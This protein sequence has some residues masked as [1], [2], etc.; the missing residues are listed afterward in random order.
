MNQ[1]TGA[2]KR[3]RTD[4]IVLGAFPEPW[5]KSL[6]DRV[7]SLS[8]VP[9]KDPAEIQDG[10][11][12]V[13]IRRHLSVPAI[14]GGDLVG[15]LALANSRRDYSERDLVRMKRL[16]SVYAHAIKRLA[17]DGENQATPRAA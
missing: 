4:R 9:T 10:F 2:G 5:S 6:T 14:V 1:T 7:H 8:N 3:F 17:T 13:P 12:R 11:V 16:A 15:L